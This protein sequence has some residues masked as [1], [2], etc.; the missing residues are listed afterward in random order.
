MKNRCVSFIAIILLLACVCGCRRTPDNRQDRADIERGFSKYL[1][2]LNTADV[3]LASEVWLQS[4]DVLVVTPVG[5]FQGWDSVR[6]DIYVNGMQK[7]F[8][9]RNV[10]A[11]NVSIVVAGDAAWLVYD[12]VFTANRGDGQPLTSKGWESHGYLRTEDGWRIAH[13]HYSVVRPAS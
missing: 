6:E 11:S 9:E 4:P 10:Q 1:Q 12:F 5:R 7:E 3:A 13:L 2:S 8:V